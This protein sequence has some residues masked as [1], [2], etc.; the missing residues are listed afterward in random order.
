MNQQMQERNRELTDEDMLDMRSPI[1]K[2]KALER[3]RKALPKIR[4]HNV[5]TTL[6]VIHNA[7]PRKQ[8]AFRK[9]GIKRNQHAW[10][11][12]LSLQFQMSYKNP[13]RA[14]I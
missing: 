9:S 5:N 10:K 12:T 14:Q 4:A 6:D 1:A 13:S 11:R 7:S 3:A 2:A 8:E